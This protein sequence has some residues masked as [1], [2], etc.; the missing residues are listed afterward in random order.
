MSV[1]HTWLSIDYDFFCWN[2]LECNGKVQAKNQSGEIKDVQA[3]W[4][5]DWG[6]NEGHPAELLDMMW[7]T[8]YEA[9]RRASINPYKVIVEQEGVA[10]IDD[11][12][13]KI[14]GRYDLDEAVHYVADS[15]MHGYQAAAY[16]GDYDARSVVHF[17]AHSDLGYDAESVFAQQKQGVCDCGSWL[18]H[19]A[20]Q[21]LVDDIT[22]VYPD[23]KGQVEWDRIHNDEHIKA[24]DV[25]IKVYSYWD[26]LRVTEQKPK[27]KIDLIF[28]CRSSSWTP[29]WL[30]ARYEKLK[31][32]LHGAE[33]HCM[34]R[35]REES[36]VR[37][38]ACTPRKWEDPTEPA[39]DLDE[40]LRQSRLPD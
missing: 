39:V 28:S 31:A 16:A 6:H 3:V 27:G 32:H 34:D 4:F 38:H 37:Y 7:L 26:W 21:G 25:S 19:A 22:I 8:R 23:W 12:A 1:Q 17:D 9:F 36:Q 18:W 30:D 20:D 40:M 2:G 15:H 14:L 5:F 11:F 24:L 33:V 29:P 35:D 10:S 13:E